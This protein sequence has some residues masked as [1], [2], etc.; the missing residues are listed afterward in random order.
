MSKTVS[1]NK[2]EEHKKYLNELHTLMFSSA[3]REYSSENVPEGYLD[4]WQHELAIIHIIASLMYLESCFKTKNHWQSSE[5][6]IDQLAIYRLLEGF[7][8][9]RNCFIHNGGAL[10][11]EYPNCVST[12][13]NLAQDLENSELKFPNT[14]KAIPKFFSINDDESISLI[15]SESNPFDLVKYTVKSYLKYEKLIV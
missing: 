8:C 6:K 14:E 10:D 15:I 13:K 9:L 11:N 12:I 5:L 2:G 4:R 1:L 3:N 7:R